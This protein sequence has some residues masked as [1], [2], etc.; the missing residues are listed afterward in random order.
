[1]MEMGYDLGKRE[2]YNLKKKKKS[3]G[4]LEILSLEGATVTDHQFIVSM[5]KLGQCWQ[6]L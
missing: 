2:Q 5:L 3:P 4:K 1:M 6:I